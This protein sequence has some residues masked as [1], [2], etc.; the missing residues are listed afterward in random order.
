[1][2][3][4]ILS[5]IMAALCLVSTV[6]AITSC[7][8]NDDNPDNG[9][10]DTPIQTL[11]HL[12]GLDF[13][14]EEINFAV[15]SSSVDDFNVRSI[16]VDEE[17]DDGDAVNSAIYARNQK[18]QTMLNVE[19]VIADDTTD[20][21]TKHAKNALLGG[22]SD[23]DVLAARQYDD[24]Q[25]ALDGVILDLDTLANEGA[26]YI[27]WNREYWASSY[28]EALSFGGKHF[29]LT[30]DLC[31]RYTSGYYALFV[32]TR[33]Y[34]D[35]LAN[36]YGSI[37][38]IVNNKQWTYD[39][40]MEMAA[41]CYEDTN[42]NDTVDTEGDRLGMLLPVWDNTNGMAI[43]AGVMF[44]R[45]D[46]NGNPFSTF[47]NGNAT[48]L[49][50]VEK[51]NQLLRTEGVYSFKAPSYSYSEAMQ[52][53]AAGEAVFVSARLNQ[54]ELFLR[55]MV[56]D[57]YVIPNPMLNKEQGAYYTGVHDA[58][59]IYGIN[60]CSEKV[61]ATAATLE[62]LAY[63]SYYSVRPIYY[64]SFLKFKYTR[65]DKAATMIDLMHDNVY[66]DFVF[67]WQF[68]EEFGDMGMFL[69]NNVV[70]NKASSNLKKVQD[71]WTKALED[72]KLKI[73]ELE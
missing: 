53:F 52:L 3:K 39:L 28:I 32:N 26:D 16:Y 42:G 72:I 27:K 59:N 58:I 45:Y 15:V 5:L 64:D 2:K 48:L 43:S 62:A 24:V 68:S 25:L 56:D 40:L 36:E 6:F 22:S 4:R 10:T 7:A 67:L 17:G 29:W 21:L 73:S 14:G 69:R 11:D 12:N 38:D 51:F 30:G 8:K 31:M 63:E 55:D 9:K 1:M 23:Y 61:A 57:Y 35:I 19:I 41:K 20:S 37:Y 70:T 66:T 46:E 44:T 60:Y 65:D 54:A 18:I 71:S 47:T 49:S 13:G 50:F 34:N 33:H